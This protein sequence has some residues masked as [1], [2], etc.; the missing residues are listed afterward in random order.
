MPGTCAVVVTF[1][2]KALLVRCLEALLAQTAAVETIL[3]VDNASTDGTPELLRERG[4]LELPQLRH[5]RMGE[6][7][8]GAGGFAAGVGAARE[9]DCDW[10]WL[11]DDDAEPRPDALARLLAAPEAQDPGTAALCPKVVFADGRVDA[12]MRGDFRRRLRYLPAAA[13]RDG[14]HRALGFTSFVGP[15]V[16]AA[17]ARRLDLPRAEFFVWADD[18]EYSLRLRAHGRLV[19][20]PESTVVHHASSHGSYTT[21]RSRLLNAISPVTFTPTPLERFWQNLCGI[22]NYLWVKRE[23]EHQS[24]LSAVGTTLQF[25][26]KH[27]LWDD[28]PATRVRWIVRFA[29]D[30]RRGRFRTIPPG[31]W[32][33]LVRRGEL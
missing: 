6:N 8:G 17:L 29:R 12:P 13:Y 10:I 4:F 19:L 9:T 1:N 20:V 33:E 32:A 23:Y 31:R 2:R 27:A 5:L 7:L 24:A 15:L 25:V 16:R 22:R 14:E 21:R 11:M 18:V 30:G 3:V 28:R 26:V